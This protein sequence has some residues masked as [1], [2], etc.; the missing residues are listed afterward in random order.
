MALYGLMADIHF[1][2]PACQQ[3]LLSEES[4][5]GLT[6]NCPHCGESLQI[7]FPAREV[8]ANRTEKSLAKWINRA[9][10]LESEL[11]EARKKLAETE[12]QAAEQRRLSTESL[13]QLHV[14]AA[15]S[16]CLQGQASAAREEAAA[17]QQRV[18]DLEATQQHL[19]LRLDQLE[20]DLSHAEHHVETVNTERAEVIT[21]AEQTKQAL[22]E[23]LAQL[24]AA[25]KE[26]RELNAA[27][28]RAQDALERT[29]NQKGAIESDHQQVSGQLSTATT[30]LTRIQRALTAVTKERDKLLGD[31]KQNPELSNLLAVKAERDR[32]EKELRDTQVA[33]SEMRENL[34]S[35]HTEREALKKER[36]ELN[37]K[38]AAMRDA[39]SDS[40][41]R[42]DNEMLRRLVERLN[43][44]LKERGPTPKKRHK[45]RAQRSRLSEMLRGLFQRCFIS[46]PDVT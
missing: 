1:S 33:V 27:L 45:K 13:H 11:S 6:I 43:E 29:Q 37:L 10:T 23:A 14:A 41:L 25:R 20:L 21:D 4:G 26:K 36:M 17:L 5:A 39:H 34:D 40:Q 32:L 28:N 22:A 24:D 38:L 31:I 18:A 7:P 3:H 16:Q 9:T 2:C 44:E 30:E 19:Y 15:E 8:A 46:D 35:F 42:E 12:R